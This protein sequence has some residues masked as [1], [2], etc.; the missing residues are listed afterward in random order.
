[1]LQNEITRLIGLF[2]SFPTIGKKT[3]TRIVLDIISKKTHIIPKFITALD[4]LQNNIKT[5]HICH[6]IDIT[7][8]CKICN[9]TKKQQDV[10]CIV[11]S[12][13]DLWAIEKT[14]V[15]NGSYHVLGGVLSAV[16]GITPDNLNLDSLQKR[17]VNNN[18]NEVIIAIN[19]NLDG[20]TT[21]YYL[22]DL[23]KKSVTQITRLGHG[24]PLGSEL[25]YLDEGTINA[26]FIYRT[27][28]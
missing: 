18:I 16:K 15:F 8:P 21:A 28:A 12:I 25:G 7:D 27:K 10:I 17:I 24:L 3:A 2:S 1:M 19:S 26:A 11:E 22:D 5:C 4:D 23:L 13:E 6:N 20:Q 9:S 14:N